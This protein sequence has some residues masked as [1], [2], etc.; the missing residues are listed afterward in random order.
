M[1]LIVRVPAMCRSRSLLLRWISGV[2]VRDPLLTFT[3]AV[4]VIEWSLRRL[5]IEPHR[6]RLSEQCD[7]Y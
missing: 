7:P 2:V 6:D 3:S 5:R 1:G 4:V